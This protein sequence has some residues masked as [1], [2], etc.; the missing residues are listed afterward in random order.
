MLF[1]D[2]VILHV[3]KIREHAHSLYLLLDV[4]QIFETVF[5]AAESYLRIFN[6]YGVA[7]GRRLQVHLI[8][9]PL[10][11]RVSQRSLDHLVI[12]IRV[13]RLLSRILRFK[14]NLFGGL[15]GLGVVLLHLFQHLF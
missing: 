1:K 7:K 15:L 11:P 13:I 8:V 6:L 2:V 12:C 5:R 4:F 9:L 3:A 14:L 10:D